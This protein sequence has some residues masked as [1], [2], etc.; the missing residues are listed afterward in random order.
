MITFLDSFFGAT[1]RRS[2][3][4]SKPQKRTE[5]HGVATA[6]GKISKRL[7]TIEQALQS[8]VED[9]PTPKVEP[10]V[11]PR[12]EQK[13]IEVP[14]VEPVVAVTEPPKT[15]EEKLVSKDT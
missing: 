13:T 6:V 9:D 14:I 8:T 10:R 4:Q 2:K 11:T 7:H 1:E 15:Q 5:Y 12:T 3:P